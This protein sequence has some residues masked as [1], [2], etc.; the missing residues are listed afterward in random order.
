MITSYKFLLMQIL[1]LQFD[2]IFLIGYNIPKNDS[3]ILKAITKRY[4][5]TY[6]SRGTIFCPKQWLLD[7]SLQE[8]WNAFIYFLRFQI[9]LHI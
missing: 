2:L 9:L 1:P 6:L 7:G 3:R 8:Q 5:F 4:D